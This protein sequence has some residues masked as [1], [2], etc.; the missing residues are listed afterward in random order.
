MPAFQITRLRAQINDLA[1]S[2]TRPEEFHAM[3]QDLFE[4]YGNPAYRPGELVMDSPIVRTYHLPPMVMNQFELELGRLCRE[5]PGPTLALADRLWQDQH[6]ETRTLA[7]FLVGQAPPTPPDPIIERLTTWGVPGIPAIILDT[8]FERG[9]RRLRHEHPLKWLETIGTWMN[10][11]ELPHVNIGLRAMLSVVND[12]DFENLPPIFRLLGKYVQKPAESL[13]S[14]LMKIL[15]AL[16]ARSPIETAYFLRRQVLT[17]TET[18][19]D[20]LRLVRRCLPLLPPEAQA[21]LRSA[22]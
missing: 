4:F 19:P 22:L 2:F 14:N 13:T 6:L 17:A 10:S 18:S 9:S 15:E 11:E 16:I 21:S 1:R 3:L 20:S 5:N 12:P 8:L 7:A